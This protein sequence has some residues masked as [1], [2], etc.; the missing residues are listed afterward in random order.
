MLTWDVQRTLWTL[1]Y[2]VFDARAN[3]FCCLLEIQLI[4]LWIPVIACIL[5][6]DAGTA[7]TLEK[8]GLPRF[9][10]GTDGSGANYHKP[11]AIHL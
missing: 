8:G 11:Q 2:G 5:F 4:K 6:G 10:L 3:V 1:A 7:T 9:I